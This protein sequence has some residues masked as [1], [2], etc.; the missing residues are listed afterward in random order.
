MS[1][2]VLAPEK[3]VDC[4]CNPRFEHPTLVDQTGRNTRV[5]A[6]LHCGMVTAVESCVDEPRAGDIRLYGH[7]ILDLPRDQFDWLAS[8]PRRV[9]LDNG[10][11]IFQPAALRCE[12]VQ[13]I[14][15]GREEQLRLRLAQRL[16][17]WPLPSSPVPRTLV[18]DLREYDAIWR[19]LQFTRETPLDALLPYADP[20]Y[21]TAPFALDVIVDRPDRDELLAEWLQGSN[22]DLRHT[23]HAVLR[24]LQP[25]PEPLLAIVIEELTQTPLT[26]S[27]ESSHRLELHD[28][29]QAT[30]DLLAALRPD[31]KKI[32]PALNDLKQR[33]G[34]RDY[35]LV[36]SIDRLLAG[37]A[38]PL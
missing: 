20:R 24:L 23:A 5:T 11:S 34:K 12:S 36:R 1:G 9:R 22:A 27:S 17:L 30:L 25:V 15:Q 33:I 7:M 29:V 10:D 32:A 38:K 19:A 18:P 2:R 16:R 14:T 8:W 28:R 37:S 31:L 35:E 4:P 3:Q 21:S 6:C 13:D 26:R